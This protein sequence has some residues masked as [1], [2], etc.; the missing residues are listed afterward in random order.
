MN[1]LDQLE[2]KSIHILREAYREFKSLCML[3]SIGKD[4]TVMLWL[5]RKAFFGH[6]PLPL[7]HIDTSYKIPE[8]IAYRD[9][10]ALEWNLN[11]VVGQNKEALAKKQ[12][13]PDGAITRLECC[14]ALKS[15]ALKHTLSGDWERMR[16][17]HTTGKYDIDTNREPYTGVIV[18]VRSDEEGSRSKERYISPRDKQNDW[19]VDDQPPELWNQYKTDFA[20]GSHVRIH[21]LLDWTELNL[22]EYIQRENIPLVDLYFDQG[23]GTRYR[24]LGCGPCTSCVQSTSKNVAEVVDEI[25]SGKFANIAERSGRAQDKDDGGG[26]ETLRRDGYM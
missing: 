7:V 12:T 23:E 15:E 8:M 11:M 14:K 22:W 2:S 25:R 26:L 5:A 18:G 20:P 19:D 4:S 16:L 1:Q 3:W 17:N 13:F 6:C 21:P 9:R 24:S 10:L